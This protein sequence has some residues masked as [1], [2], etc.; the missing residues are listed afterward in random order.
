MAWTPAGLHRQPGAGALA[1]VGA[2]KGGWV[3]D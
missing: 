3:V 2:Q 1:F